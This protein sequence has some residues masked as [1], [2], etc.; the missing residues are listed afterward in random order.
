MYAF[1]PIHTDLCTSNPQIWLLVWKARSLCQGLHVV[2]LDMAT[3][4]GKLVSITL[5]L[6][7]FPGPLLLPL[8]IWRHMTVTC[9]S[10]TEHYSSHALTAC[11]IVT[12]IHGNTVLEPA[13][14]GIERKPGRLN[15][16]FHKAIYLLCW[17]LC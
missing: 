11:L 4:S 8:S 10:C 12:V 5:S 7:S 9:H 1:N 3:Q 6:A 17:F 2:H 16:H 13:S 14:S 15:L